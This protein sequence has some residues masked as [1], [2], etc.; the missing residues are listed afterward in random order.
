MSGGFEFFLLE[1]MLNSSWA[2]WMHFRSRRGIWTHSTFEC[3]GRIVTEVQQKCPGSTYVPLGEGRSSGKPPLKTNLNALRAK[4][5]LNVEITPVVKQWK[6]TVM[7]LIYGLM[8]E[9][10]FA[11][12]VDS[13]LFHCFGEREGLLSICLFIC[14]KADSSKGWQHFEMN[15]S[16]GSCASVALCYLWALFRCS[17]EAA[18]SE[19]KLTQQTIGLSCCRAVFPIGRRGLGRGCLGEQCCLRW[20]EGH[21][22]AAVRGFHC[23]Q[24]S[25]GPPHIPTYQLN[26]PFLDSRDYEFIWGHVW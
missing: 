13:P 22:A 19:M 10:R 4:K 17:G 5:S 15:L 14:V 23:Y 8:Y 26:E 6:A 24:N 9:F 11:L 21:F 3:Y 16:L 7:C 1:G 18:S 2:K 20:G 25:R 12:V